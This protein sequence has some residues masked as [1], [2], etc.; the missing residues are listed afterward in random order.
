MRISKLLSVAF[1][2]LFTAL[3]SEAATATPQPAPPGGPIEAFATHNE[4]STTSVRHNLWNDVIGT[5]LEEGPG[6]RGEIEYGELGRLGHDVLDSYLKIM[7]GIEV[8]GLN[9][10]EQLA[11]WL[12]LYNAKSLKIMFGQ[13]K[14]VAGNKI[15]GAGHNP[16]RSK[17]VRVK[18]VYLGEDS[19]WG[20]PSLSVQ[21]VDLSLND[22]EHRILYAYWDPK[23]VL[24][25]L[26]CPARGCP[27]LQAAFNGTTVNQQ[28]AAA[29]QAFLARKDAIKVKRGRL[30]VSELYQWHMSAFGSENA[31]IDHIRGMAGPALAPDLAGIS[32]IDAYEFSW[33]LNGSEPPPD[34]KEPAGMTNRG[35]GLPAQF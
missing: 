8:S 9:R 17:R 35:S 28:L 32:S 18:K 7:Q 14:G 2:G 33:R 27:S 21:G 3:W 11:Y 25:G 4:S 26:S 15:Q 34:W 1:A 12:N 13:F 19:P 23:R 16:H 30:E 31:V 5:I 10:D 20:T 24:Y 29:A 6:G 22:I